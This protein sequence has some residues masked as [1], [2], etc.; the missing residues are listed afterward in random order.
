MMLY[1]K[2]RMFGIFNLLA[3]LKSGVHNGLNGKV[4]IVAD[5]HA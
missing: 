5:C 2:I 1:D 4:V 3:N